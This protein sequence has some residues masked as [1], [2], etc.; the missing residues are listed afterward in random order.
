MALGAALKGLRLAILG[1]GRSGLSVARAAF[2]LGGNPTLFDNAQA[3]Q[4]SKSNLVADARDLGLE[5]RLGWQGDLDPGE[6]DV[7][8]VNP[9]VDHR[10]PTLR[11]A[12]AAGIDIWSEIEF[13]YR[14]LLARFPSG[15]RP[16]I[17]AITGT[18]GKSTTTAMSYLALRACGLD[19]ILCGNIFGTGLPEL[20]F[21]DAAMTASSGQILVAEISSFQLEWVERFRP[22]V[23]TITNISPDHLDRY[24]SIADYRATK[25]RIWAQ[26]RETDIAIAPSDLGAEPPAQALVIGEPGAHACPFPDRVEILDK[27]IPA[28]DLTVVGAHNRA[29]VAMA[30]SIVAA[31]DRK[32]GRDFDRDWPYASRALCEFP[33]IA[34]RTEVVGSREGRLIINNSMCT[35]PR[36]VASS[37]EEIDGV[38]HLLIGGR[39]KVVSGSDRDHE[40]WAPVRNLLD[41]GRFRAYLYGEAKDLLNA[42][43]GGRFS[44]YNTLQEAF[45]AALDRAKPGETIMLAPGC[46]STDQFHDFR[47]R[48]NV[49]R[50]LAKEWLDS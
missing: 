21:T 7:L 45:Y 1:L 29:N 22:D 15:N 35:N 4:M 6:F 40:G 2:E 8:V 49:F 17:V 28:S 44:T 26:Q 25:L 48:G 9:A 31:V 30:G 11:A 41:T 18:N 34:H 5:M 3:E 37:A 12:K 47:E 43:F 23:A 13:G 36:A 14:A 38:V 20:T 42:Q 32:L 33:G 19:A 10:E 39:D 50:T 46:A 16:L 24:D 27:V